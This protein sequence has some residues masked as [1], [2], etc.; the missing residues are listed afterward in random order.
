MKQ[1]N[2]INQIIDS[3]F[4]NDYIDQEILKHNFKTL[5]EIELCDIL[6]TISIYK[7]SELIELNI[8]KE[9]SFEAIDKKYMLKSIRK[10]KLNLK[11]KLLHDYNNKFILCEKLKKLSKLHYGCGNFIKD[12]FLNI[13]IHHKADILLD[14]R[15]VSNIKSNSITYIYS[16]H[17]LEHLEHD[18][19]IQHL[20][21]NYRILEDGGTLRIC[22]PNFEKNFLNYA[23]DDNTILENQRNSMAASLNL[24]ELYIS[25]IDRINRSIFE[26]DHMTLMD[27]EKMKNLL[28]FVGFKS[29]N[30]LQSEFNS[31]I[32][33]KNR[34]NYSIYIQAL[35]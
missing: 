3:H 17:F 7:Q 34:I 16:E 22:L 31:E 8:R 26:W 11:V 4:F 6:A 14:A 27:F 13:D 28:I 33:S 15:K 9:S 35:K 1:V 25:K 30:I 21:E 18:E 20:K 23:Y 2:L 10:T 24:P 12:G 29:Q 5:T 19:I 32:D